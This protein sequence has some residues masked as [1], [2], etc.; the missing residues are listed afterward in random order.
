MLLINLLSLAGVL[1]NLC[2]K[3]KYTMNECM[4]MLWIKS[5]TITHLT[6]CLWTIKETNLQKE[7][8]PLFTC[9]SHCW[10]SPLLCIYFSFLT[11]NIRLVLLLMKWN[12]QYILWLRLCEYA[13]SQNLMPH[14]TNNMLAF[15]GVQLWSEHTCNH[16]NN[17]KWIH[18]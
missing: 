10:P 17:V 8:Q 13:K 15:A 18:L 12:T 14:N 2:A 4:C 11:Y 7:T 5:Q 16:G 1:R 3:W 6:V 9:I